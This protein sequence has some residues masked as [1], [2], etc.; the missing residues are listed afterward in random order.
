M[1]L[2]QS[3]SKVHYQQTTQATHL[4]INISTPLLNWTKRFSHPNQNPHSD[5]TRY[6][7]QRDLHCPDDHFRNKELQ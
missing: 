3:C 7:N 5:K 4:T 2:V 1:F 6:Q